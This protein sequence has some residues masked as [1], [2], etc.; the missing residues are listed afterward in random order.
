MRMR[1]TRQRKEFGYDNFSF[2]E[3]DPGEAPID[4]KP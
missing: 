4:L 1:I 2:I 3:R